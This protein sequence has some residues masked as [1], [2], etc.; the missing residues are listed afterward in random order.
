MKDIN[1]K[2]AIKNGRLEIDPFETAIQ[3]A[4]FK[5]SGSSG[6]DQT[7]DYIST[8][9]LKSI[10]DKIPVAFDVKI[11]GTFTSPKVYSNVIHTPSSF[12]KT[13]T[14]LYFDSVKHPLEKGIEV[15]EIYA[16]IRLI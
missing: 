12:E 7:L 4:M 16:F 8:I 9:S 5:F 15:I 1:I 11:D 14:S 13:Q 2:F 3:T 6:L 10:T